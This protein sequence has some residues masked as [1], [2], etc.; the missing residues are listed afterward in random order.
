[1][2]KNIFTERLGE[3]L[4]VAELSRRGYI[5]TTFSSNVPQIDIIAIGS[6]GASTIQVKTNA[7]GEFHVDASEWL[8]LV[9]QDGI[10]SVVGKKRRLNP[11]LVW[12]FVHPGKVYGEDLFFICTESEFQ[13]SVK[14]GYEEL[15][16]KN[17]GARKRRPEAT[18]IVM[19]FDEN[20]SDCKDK[21]EKVG[22]ALDGGESC[23]GPAK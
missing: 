13:E 16:V 22:Q 9:Q 2:A 12:V 23:V 15:L 5:A 21:W 18:H 20:L 17:E 14:K 19:H 11:N 4:A 3:A 10:Q 1:M 8:E 6:T 7:K